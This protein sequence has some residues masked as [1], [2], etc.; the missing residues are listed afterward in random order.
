MKMKLVES[1]MASLRA[2]QMNYF[3]VRAQDERFVDVKKAKR[4]RQE[5]YQRRSYISS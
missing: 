5:G 4:R 1:M 3:C 2:R